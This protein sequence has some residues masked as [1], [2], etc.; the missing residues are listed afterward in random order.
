MDGV[1]SK[2]ARRIGPDARPLSE[3]LGHD[4][5][6]LKHAV[7]RLGGRAVD[8]RTSVGKALTQWQQQLVADLGGEDAISTQE[9]AV[10]DLALRTKLLLDSI[11]AWL[12]RQPTLVNAR[13]RAVIPVVRERTQLADALARY[14]TAL[15]LKRRVKSVMPLQEYLARLA[16]TTDRPAPTSADGS[17]SP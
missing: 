14:L 17:T 7:K 4:L 6:T 15:G 13:R 12:L 9:R 10:I 1:N 11:D 3:P 2:K 5:A 8:R 16:A